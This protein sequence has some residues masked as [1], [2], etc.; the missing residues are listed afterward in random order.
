MHGAARSEISEFLPDGCFSSELTHFVFK[1]L[2]GGEI[3]EFNPR[4][5]DFVSM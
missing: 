3:C 4:R 2:Q 1:K 5:F